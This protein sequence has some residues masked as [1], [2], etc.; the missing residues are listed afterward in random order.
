MTSTFAVSS[1]FSIWTPSTQPP[2]RI[3]HPF[4]DEASVGHLVPSRPL[5]S[6]LR[7]PWPRTEGAQ[8]RSN[9]F[10]GRPERHAFIVDAIEAFALD[11]PA[12]SSRCTTSRTGRRTL[13]E[14][15][16]AWT[17]D[18]LNETT[19]AFREETAIIKWEKQNKKDFCSIMPVIVALTSLGHFFFYLPDGSGNGEALVT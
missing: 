5:R 11:I 8:T 12:S 17:S 13:R 7:R 19:R 3:S 6:D 16:R 9:R 14:F 15:D 18:H 10:A 1:A 2:Q 4:P